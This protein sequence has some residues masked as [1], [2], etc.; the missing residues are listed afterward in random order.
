MIS[1]STFLHFYTLPWTWLLS[2]WCFTK[3]FAL[4]WVIFNYQF[5]WRSS[6]YYISFIIV[7]Y[8]FYNLGFCLLCDLGCVWHVCEICHT[9]PFFIVFI[10]E[11]F[12]VRVYLDVFKMVILK[13]YVSH[14][15]VTHASNLIQFFLPFFNSLKIWDKMF[16]NFHLRIESCIST[17]MPC[18]IH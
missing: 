2:N 17:R 4:N 1:L 12:I 14:V 16:V 18:C 10:I 15:I 9:R 11:I 3:S 7:N 13:A 5:W 8:L 6:K